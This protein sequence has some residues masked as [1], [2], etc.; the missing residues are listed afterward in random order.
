MLQSSNGGLVSLGWVSSRWQSVHRERPPV[1]EGACVGACDASWG[2]SASFSKRHDGTDMPFAKR[3]LEA[4][5]IV[6]CV[7]D[8]QNRTL[9]FSLNGTRR[10]S[11][12]ALPALKCIMFQVWGIPMFLLA[13]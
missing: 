9:S 7:A 4:G 3:L 8:V 11:R 5:D 10:V 13:I 6:G 1:A 12:A 2:V